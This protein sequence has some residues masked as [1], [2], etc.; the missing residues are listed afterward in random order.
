MIPL[1]FLIAIFGISMAGS[2][3]TR[4]I[5]IDMDSHTERPGDF[6]GRTG[7]FWCAGTVFV[8]VWELSQDGINIVVTP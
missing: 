3:L 8:I 1:P 4:L 5:K 6:W 2:F 7:K